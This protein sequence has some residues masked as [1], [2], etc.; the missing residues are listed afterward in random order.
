MTLNLRTVIQDLFVYFSGHPTK[1][2]VS[3]FQVKAIS[4]TT[5]SFYNADMCII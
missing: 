5:N 3:I 1:R 2:T 4:S